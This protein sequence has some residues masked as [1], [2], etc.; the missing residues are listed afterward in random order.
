MDDLISIY[1]YIISSQSS[2]EKSQEQL[3]SL[4]T[5]CYDSSLELET[6]SSANGLDRHF[7]YLDCTLSIIPTSTSHTI[8]LS[9]YMKN[10]ESIRCHHK[11]IFYNYQHWK[12]YSQ[13]SVKIGVIKSTVLRLYR[14]SNHN[15]TFVFSIVSLQRELQL[16]QYPSYVL[17]NILKSCYHQYQQS[18][19]LRTYQILKID[20]IIQSFKQQPSSIQIATITK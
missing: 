17:L 8:I 7:T 1:A 14:N 11:Q 12:S 13:S 18:L 15:M 3:H 4:L 20:H 2:L 9:P 19:Y 16:L 6:T 10:S 5:N